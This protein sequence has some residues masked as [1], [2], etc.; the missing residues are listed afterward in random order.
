MVP[1]A[2]FMLAAFTMT[3]ANRRFI[4]VDFFFF[5]RLLIVLYTYICHTMCFHR[6]FNG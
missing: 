3:T 5:L 6:V 1:V 4:I 2:P